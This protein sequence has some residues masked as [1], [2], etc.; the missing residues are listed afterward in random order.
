[1]DKRIFVMVPWSFGDEGSGA[2]FLCESYE[3]DFRGGIF[4]LDLLKINCSSLSTM[5]DTLSEYLSDVIYREATEQNILCAKYLWTMLL[6]LSEAPYGHP[7]P[8]D[9]VEKLN[10]CA[11]NRGFTSE[12]GYFFEVDEEWWGYVE[13]IVRKHIGSKS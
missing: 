4:T 12:T 7:I 13:D 10:Q 8:D 1:M 9:L 5:F 11:D 6:L 2:M 3:V